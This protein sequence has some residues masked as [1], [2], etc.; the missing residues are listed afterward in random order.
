MRVVLLRPPRYVWPFNSE[1]SAFWQPL[2]LLCLAAAVRRDLPGARWR[3]GTAP[4]GGG[5]GGR[6]GGGWPSG[7]S[8]CWAWGRRPSRRTR[9]CG[10]RNWSSSCIP[11]C[12]VV[13]GGVYFA[14]AIEPTLRSGPGGRDRPRRRGGDLLPPAGAR[15]RPRRLAEASRGWPSCDDAGQVVRTPPRAL[16]ADLDDLPVPAYDLVE[17]DDYGRASRN[18]PNLVSIEHSR[19]CIDSCSFCILWKHMGTSANGDGSARPCYRS[20]SAGAASRRCAGCTTASAGGRSAGWT[21]RST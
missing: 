21:P 7:P 1:T 4:R 19:G 16:V 10:R 17:M 5:V 15:R 20:K 9:P 13:A 3:C 12:L 18:H 6:C 14:Y 8:T 2:G 11:R